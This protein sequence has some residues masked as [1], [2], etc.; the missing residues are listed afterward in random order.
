MKKRRFFNLSIYAEGGNAA[1][2]L[3]EEEGMSILRLENV[4]CSYENK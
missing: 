3:R 2:A 1:F 4:T